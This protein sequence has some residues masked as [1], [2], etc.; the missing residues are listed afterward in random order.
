MLKVGLLFGSFNPVHSAHL[1]LGQYMLQFQGLDELWYVVSPQNP[2]KNIDD[3]ADAE[4]RVE[5]LRLATQGAKSMRVCD[6]ELS[7]PVPSYTI[8]TLEKL[9]DLYP[10]YQFHIVMGADNLVDFE[11][12][13]NSG[14]ILNK[15]KLLIYPRLGFVIENVTH[16]NIVAT[17]APIFELSSTNIRKWIG[18]GN[19]VSYFVPD[20]VYCYINKLNLYR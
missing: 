9:S 11:E 13:K 7:M 16:E 18:D 6:I 2:F 8:D 10:D 19:D 20:V 5:M 3:L 4:H 15:Y 17:A 14:E 12:W 1:M